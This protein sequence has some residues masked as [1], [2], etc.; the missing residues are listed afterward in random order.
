MTQI[1]TTTHEINPPVNFGPGVEVKHNGPAMLPRQY[2]MNVTALSVHRPRESFIQF[3]Y[4]LR[5]LPSWYVRRHWMMQSPLPMHW[6]QSGTALIK[7]RRIYIFVLAV[8]GQFS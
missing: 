2:P 4:F 1:M 8:A 6:L 3:T 5:R 7:P